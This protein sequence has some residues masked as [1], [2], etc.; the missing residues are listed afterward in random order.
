[1]DVIE[2]GNASRTEVLIKSTEL[3]MSML[4]EARGHQAAIGREFLETTRKTRLEEMTLGKCPVC[5]TGDLRVLRSKKTRKGFVGR[6]NYWRQGCGASAP[7]P[8]KGKV[9][10]VG[11]ACR[12]CGWPRVKILLRGRRPWMICA[13]LVCSLKETKISQRNSAV[14]RVEDMQGM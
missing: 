3:L 9:I 13:S 4:N 8:Q 11:G 6:S 10:P 1:M 14:I 2:R 5:K 12:T 7:L